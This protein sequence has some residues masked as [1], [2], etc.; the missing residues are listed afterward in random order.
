MEND[1]GLMGFVYMRRPELEAMGRVSCT[2]E[3]PL[4]ISA[5]PKMATS[6]TKVGS[7]GSLRSEREKVGFEVRVRREKITRYIASM[8]SAD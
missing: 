5:S 2:E 6:E 4:M 1:V 8:I 7:V 3:P